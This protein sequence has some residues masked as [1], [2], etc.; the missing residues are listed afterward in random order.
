MNQ[1][2]P[3]TPVTQERIKRRRD[4]NLDSPDPD[5]REIAAICQMALDSLAASEMSA[6]SECGDTKEPRPCGAKNCPFDKRGTPR[7]DAALDREVGNPDSMAVV[8][9]ARQLE[10]DNAQ[11]QYALEQSEAKFAQS[12]TS[13][14]KYLVRA[15]GECPQ[16][17][18]CADIPE[19]QAA[20]CEALFGNPKDADPDEIGHLL[21][22]VQTMPADQSRFDWQYEDGWVE[23]T[24]LRAA[25]DRGS[26]RG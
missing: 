7:T 25:A 5:D 2:D 19:V 12:A 6:C 26:S 21:K 24:K 1:P 17:W 10:R 22:L 9:L 14:P 11:L 16:D 23:V 13:A 15:G 8:S 4:V 20:L 3:H 18:L